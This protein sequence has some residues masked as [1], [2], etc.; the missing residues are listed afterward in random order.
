SP[1]ADPVMGQNETILTGALLLAIPVAV[2]GGLVQGPPRRA[3][4]LSGG[5]VPA[6]GAPGGRG[7]GVEPPGG[8]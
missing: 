3:A 6:P 5:V 1:R 2:F 4:A 8:A 7:R